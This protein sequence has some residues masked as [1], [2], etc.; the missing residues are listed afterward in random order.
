MHANIYNTQGEKIKEIELPV[1]FEE[2]IR[3]DLIKRAVLAI[4]SHKRQPY[5][6]YKYAGLEASAWTSKRRRSYRSSY[7]RGISRVPRAIL[8]RNGGMFVWVARVVPNAVKGRRAH[9]PKPE[10]NWYEKINKKERRKA[11][12]SAIAATA[13]PHFVLSR[14]ERASEILKPVVDKFGLPIVLESSIEEFSKAK[15]LKDTLKNLSIYDFIKYVK[16]TRRQRAGKGKRRGRRTKMSRGLL[17]VVGDT[18][19]PINRISLEGVEIVPVNKLNAEVLAP[20]AKPGRF[21]I[22]TE[23]AIKN[24]EDLFI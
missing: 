1:H 12:R 13:N 19:S 6:S 2:E 23:S 16:E 5:G 22:W 21:T 14:Y 10:K 11:I 18:K 7:G 17:L 15:Q 8:I 20:G 3:P 9:P 4:Y 24:L